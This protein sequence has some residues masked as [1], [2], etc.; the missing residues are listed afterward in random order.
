VIGESLNAIQK[1]GGLVVSVTTDG[2]ITNLADVESRLAQNYLMSEYK[3]IRKQL[4]DDETGL[5]LKHS[6]KGIL[7]WTTRGQLGFESKI[8]ATTGFQHYYSIPDM[9][10][11][12]TETFKSKSKGIEFV[13]TRL[14][15]AKD[16][17]TNGGHVTMIYKDQQ[18]RMH[19]YNKRV[20]LIPLEG[21]L[22]VA[23]VEIEEVL[24]DSN[25]LTDISHGENLRFISKVSKVKQ[26]SKYSNTSNNPNRY[27]ILQDL[28]ITNFVKGLLAE[29]PLF[30]LHRVGLENYKDIVEYIK[31]FNPSTKIT[32]NSISLLKNRS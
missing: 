2:F 12:F 18:F 27:L 9:I 7:A 20:W 3:K 15:S 16:V 8:I 21:T 31:A 23:N 4:S 13:Q 30:K 11:V 19:F 1:L 24:L 10:T 28:A 29:P 22:P 25:P 32:P 14:R 17:Y 26:Y 6:G 5:E